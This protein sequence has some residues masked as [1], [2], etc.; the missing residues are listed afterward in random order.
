MT[1]IPPG[2]MVGA[3]PPPP[4][5]TPNFVNPPNSFGNMVALHTVCLFLI[6]LFLGLR[7]YT[8]QFITH[9]LKVDDCTHSLICAILRFRYN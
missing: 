6:T 2:M 3:I 4:G 9:S 8:R 5:V 1:S 7:L